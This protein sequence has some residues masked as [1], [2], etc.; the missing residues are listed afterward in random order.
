MPGAC[1]TEHRD[2]CD[3]RGVRAGV[4]PTT[5]ASPSRERRSARGRGRARGRSRARTPSP[6]RRRRYTSQRGMAVSDAPF[7]GKR[8]TKGRSARGRCRSRTTPTARARRQLSNQGHHRE[9][10]CDGAHL[11]GPPP[12]QSKTRTILHQVGGVSAGHPPYCVT[13]VNQYNAADGLTLPSKGRRRSGVRHAGNSM[14]TRGILAERQ[15]GRD[16]CAPRQD[17][18]GVSGACGKCRT[19]RRRGRVRSQWAKARRSPS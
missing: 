11:A 7:P 4:P 18:V 10:V 2:E 5:P 8:S 12:R 16:Q 3:A 19:T 6:R 15:A 14:V 9:E 13:V 17:G 1:A